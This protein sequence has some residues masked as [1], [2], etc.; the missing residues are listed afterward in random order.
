[1]I[2][3]P[4]TDLSQQLDSIERR[5]ANLKGANAPEYVDIDEAGKILH[6]SKSAIYKKTMADELPFYKFGKNLI[7]KRAE[8]L[9]FISNH[10]HNPGTSQGVQIEG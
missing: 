4:F 2:N 6:L 9:D 7:F 10:R 1:M 8:L 3:N 5:L